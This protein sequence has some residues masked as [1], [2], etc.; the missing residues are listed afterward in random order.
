MR[1]EVKDLEDPDGWPATDMIWIFTA[2]TAR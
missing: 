2:A 1:I